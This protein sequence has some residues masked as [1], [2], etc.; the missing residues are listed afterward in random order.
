VNFLQQILLLMRVCLVG[1]REA[2]ERRG[3]LRGDLLE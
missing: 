2:R 3:E 1:A